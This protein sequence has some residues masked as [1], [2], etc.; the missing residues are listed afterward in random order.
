M[1]DYG[2]YL[3]IQFSMATKI[4]SI[5]PHTETQL[6]PDPIRIRNPEIKYLSS[7][8]QPSITALQNKKK[9]NFTLAVLA[10]GTRRWHLSS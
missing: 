7:I 2:I 5:D 9:K 8:F 1:I 6:N 10:S 4:F 3:T